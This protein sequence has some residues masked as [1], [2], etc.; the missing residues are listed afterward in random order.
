MKAL[1]IIFEYIKYRRIG[2][3]IGII[4][5]IISAFV[6]YLYRLDTDAV[7]YA[8]LLC[9]FMSLPMIIWDL[10]RFIRKHYVM[11]KIKEKVCVDTG[12]IPNPENLCEEDYTELIEALMNDKRS[13]ISEN[14][15]N[16]RDM[17]D[18][19][20][21]WAHQIKTP[22]S[23]MRLLLQT[24]DILDKDMISNELFNIEQYVEMVLS[25]IRSDDSSNDFVFRKYNADSIVRQAVRKYAP[26]F[27][28]KKLTM[29]YRELGL[30]V[31]TDEKWLLFAIEQIISNSLKYTSKGGVSVY[32]S[33]GRSVTIEDS[34]I[35]ISEE[36]LPRVCEKG[37]TG[38][39]GR[40]NK[41]ST[42]L[43]LYLCKRILN[44]LGHTIKIES[45]EG[46]GTRITIGL[47]SNV[48]EVE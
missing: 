15:K 38:F 16:K 9:V 35:G 2:I 47:E 26:L 44:K 5:I 14:D 39:N 41:K 3:M 7:L 29:D 6:Y 27:I 25:Y 1:K 46:K 31:V 20:T 42:G 45:E 30:D 36:D 11:Q 18:Y 23:A 17:L 24:D 32:S 19:Y 48:L 4:Y 10:V 21:L 34:G 13:I 33:D 43:G 28:R 40:S 37:F 12:C 8:F 22:I